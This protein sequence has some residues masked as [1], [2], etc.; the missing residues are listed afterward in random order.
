MSTQNPNSPRPRRRI[1][2]ERKGQRSVP[3]A[4]ASETTSS[5]TTSQAGSQEP[6]PPASPRAADRPPAPSEP[7]VLRDDEATGPPARPVPGRVLIGLGLLT[8]VLV[9]L[10][11]V[12]VVEGTGVKAF[13][14]VDEQSEVEDSTRTA[15]AAA[16]RAAEAIL[17]YDYRSLEADRDAA[18]RFMT[19]DYRKQYLDTFDGLVLKA[20][21]ERKA[22]VEASVRASGVVAAGADRVEVLLFVNQVTV[23]TANSGE[24]QTA[25]NRVMFAMV[26][27]GSAW[28]VDDITSY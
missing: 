9:V 28:R 20:A 13:Q 2:G 25:L 16:E 17:A 11:T 26:R 7:P 19:S 27:D 12:G 8:A 22:K 4:E 14:A 3:S 21:T 15:P 10:A 24:P 23:S 5:E 6:A 1:A 18:A